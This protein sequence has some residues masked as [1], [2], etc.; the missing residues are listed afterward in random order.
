VSIAGNRSWPKSLGV[1]GV[2][3][4]DQRVLFHDVERSI[5]EIA[6]IGARRVRMRMKAV[7]Y[8]SASIATRS[9][10]LG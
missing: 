10:S 5:D 8:P 9:E 4:A 2:A 1:G 6:Q 3:P 7:T